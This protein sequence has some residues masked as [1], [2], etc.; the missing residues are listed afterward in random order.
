MPDAVGN[1]P[2]PPGLATWMPSA[3]PRVQVHRCRSGRV[4]PEDRERGDRRDARGPVRRLIPRTAA[5]DVPV[6]LRP[7]GRPTAAGRPSDSEA[8]SGGEGVQHR[9]APLL[10]S[11]SGV[12]APSPGS[13]GANW[14]R[15]VE[16]N[17]IRRNRKGSWCESG[18]NTEQSGIG[19]V[20]SVRIHI[21]YEWP[22]NTNPKRKRGSV[23]PSLTLRG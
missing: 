7:R 13:R 15:L 1:R 12:W 2:A 3:R 21:S 6:R 14:E 18:A 5:C 19:R 9:S 10:E 20:T 22:T 16:I 17:G 4:R 8:S 23:T 11:D